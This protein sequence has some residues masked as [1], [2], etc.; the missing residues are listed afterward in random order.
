MPDIIGGGGVKLH[1]VEAGNPLGTPLLFIHGYCQS[2]N[3]WERQLRGELARDFRLIAFDLRGHGS[4]GKPSELAAYG[5][6]SLWATDVALVLEHFDLQ[7]TVLVGWSYGGLVI[8]DYLRVFGTQRI[9]ALAF[10]DAAVGDARAHGFLAPGYTALFPAIFSAEKATFDPALARLVELCYAPGFALDE[11]TRAAR[12]EISRRVPA[13]AREGM[14]RGRN[15]DV[16]DVLRELELPVLCAHGAE[17]GV[18][19]PAASERTAGIVPNAQLSLYPGVGHSPFFEAGER[20]NRELAEL[21]AR[22]A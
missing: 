8:A 17:D 7:R 22:V 4:S 11:G 20:F 15:R 1:V 14:M 5:D 6:S 12:L 19:L 2:A 13:V 3:S 16:D 18:V 9:G 21:A 10:V